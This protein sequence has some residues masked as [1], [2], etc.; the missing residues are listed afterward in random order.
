MSRR[1]TPKAQTAGPHGA[2]EMA[3]PRMKEA[4]SG[5]RLQESRPESSIGRRRSPSAAINLRRATPRTEN[6]PN[7]LRGSCR[8]LLAW[9][10]ARRRLARDERWRRDGALKVSWAKPRARRDLWGLNRGGGFGGAAGVRG[11]DASAAHEAIMIRAV[12]LWVLGPEGRTSRERSV[13]QF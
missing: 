4:A 1:M 13:G 10:R 12:A 6:A 2:Y 7:A 9:R 8:A 3:R 11:E 5:S